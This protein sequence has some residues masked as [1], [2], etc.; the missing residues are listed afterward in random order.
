MPPAYES[1]QPKLARPQDASIEGRAGRH[2]SARKR[3][4]TW[5]YIRPLNVCSAFAALTKG[6]S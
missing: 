6:L 4:S 2:L 5:L 3:S 1:A